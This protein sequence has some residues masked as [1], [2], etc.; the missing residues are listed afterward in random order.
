LLWTTVLGTGSFPRSRIGIVTPRLKGSS[1]RPSKKLPHRGGGEK[2]VKVVYKRTGFGKACGR[3]QRKRTQNCRKEG[4]G[5]GLN[6]KNGRKRPLINSKMLL[7]REKESETGGLHPKGQR[8]WVERSVRKA[9]L[10]Q[11]TLRGKGEAWR[12]TA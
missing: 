3:I 2:K 7:G 4:S 8:S 9:L 5:E 1:K 10:V 6:R 11:T 12:I